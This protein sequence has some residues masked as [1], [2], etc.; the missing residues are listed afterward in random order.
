MNET[1]AWG[2]SQTRLRKV[3]D[4]VDEGDA[5]KGPGEGERIAEIG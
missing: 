1:D 4:G 5:T 3:T 2:K